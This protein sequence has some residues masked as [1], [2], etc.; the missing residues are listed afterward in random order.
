[1]PNRMCGPQSEI[2]PRCPS[3]FQVGAEV[4]G[5]VESVSKLRFYVHFVFDLIRNISVL[6]RSSCLGAIF[7]LYIFIYFI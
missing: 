6:Y 3:H 2:G 5:K 4:L 1:M 7:Q